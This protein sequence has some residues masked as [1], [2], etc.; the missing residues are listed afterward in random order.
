LHD[1]NLHHLNS[2][3]GGPTVEPGAAPHEIVAAFQRK[4][5]A[6]ALR[7][8][9]HFRRLLG[10]TFV[11]NLAAAALAAAKLAFGWPGSALPWGTLL[12]LLGAL[13]VATFVRY[14]RSQHHWTRCRL[15]AEITRSALAIWGLP[16][17]M[18][19]FADFNWAG[20]EPLRRS[21]DVLHRRAA[22]VE[23]RDFEVFKRHYL[24]GRLEI[25]LAY[26]ARRGGRAGSQLARLRMVFIACV[27]AAIVLTAG[28]A[29]QETMGWELLP[30]ADEAVL[31]R[32]APIL[33]PM[34]AA[35]CIALISIHDLHR[36][37]A[38][39]REMVIRLEA[40][41]KEIAHSKTWAGLERAI[42]KAE[43]VLLQE[44]FEW[45]SVT[46]FPEPG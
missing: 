15:A 4:V 17:A 37:L 20:L 41:R 26:F 3:S 33:L 11:L 22:R 10:V 13:G 2:L 1:A 42:A 8:S 25:Q 34:L 6:A 43:R 32:F 14:Q 29:L 7:S 18:R 46:S 44:L 12:C 24:S 40:L 28:Y 5:D 38:R 31:F 30:P 36:R 39:C 21:L 19:L 16:R 35:A 27:T 45:H 23:P 9:P